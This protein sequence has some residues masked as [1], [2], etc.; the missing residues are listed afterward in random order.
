MEKIIGILLR[1][2]FLN[3]A[4]YFNNISY[5]YIMSPLFLMLSYV[6]ILANICQM[7]PDVIANQSFTMHRKTFFPSTSNIVKYTFPSTSNIV[8]Y[9]FS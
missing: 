9:T 7:H 5:A 4:L 2:I 6:V 3:M 1:R 8:K